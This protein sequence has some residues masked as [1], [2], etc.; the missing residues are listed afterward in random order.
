MWHMAIWHGESVAASRKIVISRNMAKYQR[1]RK[2][3][4]NIMA[5]LIMKNNNGNM[6]SASK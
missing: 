1:R 5:S 3:S 4:N 6:A 2:K